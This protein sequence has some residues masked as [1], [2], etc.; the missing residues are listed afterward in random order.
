MHQTGATGKLNDEQKKEIF[1][2]RQAGVSLKEI[3]NK[4]KISDSTVSYWAD[5]KKRD[6][7]LLKKSKGKNKKTVH[8]EPLRLV[9]EPQKPMICIFGSESQIT[10]AIREL[11]S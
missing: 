4:F 11:F 10:K 9:E 7:I 5:N 2:L 3:S 8:M 1:N 6:K